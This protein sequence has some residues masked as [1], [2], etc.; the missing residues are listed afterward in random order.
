MDAL[1]TIVINELKD[2]DHLSFD[3]E[4]PRGGFSFF[5]QKHDD[6]LEVHSWYAGTLSQERSL[7]YMLRFLEEHS[8]NNI[9]EPRLRVKLRLGQEIDIQQ[10]AL[11]VMDISVYNIKVRYPS[12]SQSALQG[13]NTFFNIA[14]SIYG[15]VWAIQKDGDIEPIRSCNLT[16]GVVAV[17]NSS[18][19]SGTHAHRDANRVI[20]R[21]WES[22]TL[23][24]EDRKIL[25]NYDEGL[26]NQVTDVSETEFLVVQYTP[27]TLGKSF[28]YGLRRDEIVGFDL[29]GHYDKSYFGVSNIRGR[30]RKPTERTELPRI[31][32]DEF[33]QS[34]QGLTD[35]LNYMWGKFQKLTGVTIDQAREA[36]EQGR[37]E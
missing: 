10:H 20:Q 28:A 13:V 5:V 35:R 3:V 6:G 1:S 16:T 25:S 36:I 24:P 37:W 14:R 31:Q 18:M 17:C 19:S 15:L 12:A 11:P 21:L 33:D 2:R 22:G 34:E 4:S 29:R 32:F 27:T 23:S 9:E 8:D 30:D 26:T 7:K